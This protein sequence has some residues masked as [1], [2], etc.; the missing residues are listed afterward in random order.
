M[1]RPFWY[2]GMLGLVLLGLVACAPERLPS[3]ESSVE[4]IIR[5]ADEE[6][7]VDVSR[8]PLLETEQYQLL[9]LPDDHEALQEEVY[10]LTR[11]EDLTQFPCSRCHTDS[12]AT[13]RAQSEQEGQ[14]QHW[15]ISLVHASTQTMTCET[16]HDVEENVDALRTLAGQSVDFDQS[17]QVCAQCHASQFEDWL[18]GAH[19]K[20]VGGWASPRVMQTCA[21][22]HDPHEPEWD[23]R[24]PAVPPKVYE[25]ATRP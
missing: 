3:S 11:K 9:Q 8:L 4:E 1:K 16:C 2:L 13:L 17:Y 23:V 10:V 6:V 7:S 21:D 15:N 5:A 19:G 24:W 25:G 20:Q 22:C 12:L 14:L 18:G